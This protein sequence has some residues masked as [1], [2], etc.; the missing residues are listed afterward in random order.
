MLAQPSIRAST[1]RTCARA[2][3]GRAVVGG[4]VGVGG[5]DGGC[6]VG[7]GEGEDVGGDVGVGGRVDV[8]RRRS[9]ALKKTINPER[10]VKMQTRKGNVHA[11]CRGWRRRR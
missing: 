9:T 2:A 1:A 6:A 7:V 4:A 11:R 8:E 10:A 5:E 3:V